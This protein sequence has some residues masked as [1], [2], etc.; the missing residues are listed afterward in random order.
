MNLKVYINISGFEQDE[1]ERTVVL[2]QE[3]KRFGFFKA[4]HLISDL[5]RILFQF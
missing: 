5:G 1:V 3:R 2:L 4:F